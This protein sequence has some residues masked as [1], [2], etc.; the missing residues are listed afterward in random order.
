MNAQK[1]AHLTGAFGLGCLTCWLIQFPLWMIGEPP[2][3]YDGFGL[4]RHLFTIKN[5]A[6][7]RSGFYNAGGG[8]CHHS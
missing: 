1:V 3:V 2:S 4:A 7:T 5:I 8:A 6:F